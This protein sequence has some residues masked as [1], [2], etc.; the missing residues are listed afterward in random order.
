MVLTEA[1]AL[2]SLLLFDASL[3][4]VASFEW[5]QV[6]SLQFSD[7][8]LIIWSMFARYY[9]SDLPNRRQRWTTPYTVHGRKFWMLLES[10]R[11]LH[12]KLSCVSGLYFKQRFWE[13]L[14]RFQENHYL[15]LSNFRRASI[16]SDIMFVF[17]L[18]VLRTFF[19]VQKNGADQEIKGN[20]WR[21]PNKMGRTCTQTWPRRYK[22]LFYLRKP[23]MTSLQRVNCVA[24]VAESPALELVLLLVLFVLWDTRV[25]S[26]FLLVSVD[27]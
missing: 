9:L 18:L 1:K 3:L 16:Y 25:F 23:S 22:F 17:H 27:A 20:T 2:K 26:E 15:L 19:G 21:K 7:N 10:G 4:I 24:M 12:W 5:L 14:K 8:F 13:H 11:T 6:I